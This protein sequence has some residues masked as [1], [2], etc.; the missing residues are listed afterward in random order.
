M[1][2]S[3]R[4]IPI[5][6]LILVT[7]GADKVQAEAV[8]SNTPT[9]GQWIECTED[10]TSTDDIAIDL[11]SGV[12][13]TTT[14][15][16]DHGIFG[17]HEGAGDITINVNGAQNN[18]TI[19]T[20]GL[21]ANGVSALSKDKGSVDITVT[22]VD[23]TTTGEGASG[24]VSH[25]VSARQDFGLV[26][27]TPYDGTYNVKIKVSD[28]Q[29]NTAGTE[30]DGIIGYHDGNTG[31]SIINRG[32]LEITASNTNIT[33]TGDFAHGMHAFAPNT[34]GD[35]M[36][37][38]TGGLISTAGPYAHGI[39]GINGSETVTGQSGNVIF[40]VTDAD[41][42]T[43]Y[44]GSVPATGINDAFGIEAYNRVDGEGDVTVT[45]INTDISTMG[46]KAEGIRALRQRGDGDVA[47]TIQGGEITTNHSQAY[48]IF[49]WHD[50]PAGATGDV[51]IDLTG[52]HGQIGR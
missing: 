5:V 20:G 33:T 18:K 25:G 52:C 44:D 29:I 47:I 30:S 41:I 45:L 34:E 38:V 42:K 49:G 17:H 10:A 50:G 23:I 36:I 8:C 3:L 13:I 43:T 19:T 22:N 39:Y 21:L 51:N 16:R 28:S 7:L 35:V 40:H 6:V 46:P 26:G 14:G 37:T 9:A 32:N 27:Q 11:K 12:N 1:A 15:E 2:T 48:A 4:L 31:R 24:Q